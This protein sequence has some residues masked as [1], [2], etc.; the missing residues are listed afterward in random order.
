MRQRAAAALPASPA[1]QRL[2]KPLSTWRGQ[3]LQREGSGGAGARYPWL[4]GSPAKSRAV[5]W[6]WGGE[7]S[8]GLLEPGLEPQ[9]CQSSSHWVLWDLAAGSLPAPVPQPHPVLSITASSS[10]SS[11][12]LDPLVSPEGGTRPA[13]GAG[14]KRRLVQPG[15]HLVIMYACPRKGNFASQRFPHRSHAAKSWRVFWVTGWHGGA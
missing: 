6:G 2:A 1:E 15:G 10:S 12:L 9:G 13:L 8:S 5:L 11:F 7:E 14:E 4:W 3:C